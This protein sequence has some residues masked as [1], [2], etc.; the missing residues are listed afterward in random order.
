[1]TSTSVLERADSAHAAE[2]V[3]A[4]TPPR[5]L[6]SVPSTE[7]PSPDRQC[8][9][10]TADSGASDSLSP[11]TRALIQWLKRSPPNPSALGSPPIVPRDLEGTNTVGQADGGMN[12]PA[13]DA[14]EGARTTQAD[15]RD[16]AS[17]LR[18][19]TATT[20]TYDTPPA[21]PRPT[22]PASVQDRRGEW[23]IV[24]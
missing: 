4:G 12:S 7:L 11:R 13:E 2:R 17:E 16:Q 19:S 15:P 8:T 20:S 3:T 23:I 24:E 5:S 14:I 22:R 9:T 21:A 6:S 18:E 1:M 10:P